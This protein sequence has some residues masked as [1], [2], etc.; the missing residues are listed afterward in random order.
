MFIDKFLNFI[1]QDDK[2]I[3]NFF[4]SKILSDI[5]YSS[6]PLN[7]G[8]NASLNPL[9]NKLKQIISNDIIIAGKI[10]KCGN[11]VHMPLASDNNVPKLV[12]FEPP[13][14]TIP[15]KLNILSL[16]ITLGITKAD[17]VIIVPSVLGKICFQ[18]I[19]LSLAPNVLAAITYSWFLNR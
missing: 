17:D 10:I 5:L 16:K 12:A 18:I 1:N 13:K 15:K 7:V 6:T 2:D 19:L 9:P 14:L 3:F 8:L 4:T 11:C